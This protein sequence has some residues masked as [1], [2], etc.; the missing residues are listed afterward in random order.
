[1]AYRRGVAWGNTISLL[2]DS[3]I[4]CEKGLNGSPG[5]TKGKK[6]EESRATSS[7]HAVT[8]LQR[9]NHQLF[10]RNQF[11]LKEFRPQLSGHKQAIGLCIVCNTVENINRLAT[12]FFS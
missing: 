5:R 10:W 6:T 1:M 2:C 7:G 11:N 9:G 3:F 8:W 12:V 4:D